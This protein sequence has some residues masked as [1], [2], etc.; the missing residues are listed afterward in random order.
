M[1]HAEELLNR[2]K[3]LSAISEVTLDVTLQAE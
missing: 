2:P 1:S 3:D